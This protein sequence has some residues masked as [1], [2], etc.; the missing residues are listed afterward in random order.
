[1]QTNR[2]DNRLLVV[3]I[4]AAHSR[5]GVDPERL[6]LLA[7]YLREGV[8]SQGA[9]RAV[10]SALALRENFHPDDRDALR[11]FDIAAILGSIS[12]MKVGIVVFIGL[13]GTITLLIGGI[14]IANFHLA[15]LEERAAEI[16]VAK[17]LGARNRSLVA[18]TVLE[19]ALVSTTAGLLGLGVGYAITALASRMIPPG[20]FPTPEVS[21][22]VAMVTLGTLVGVTGLAAIV[23]ARRVSRIDISLAL[24]EGT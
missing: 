4:T 22:S 17:A 18:Q 12:L 9:L 14:G 8:D 7:V 20:L 3:P 10:T 13:A 24:R 19:S 23:P 1:M 16:G 5:R 15:T 6:S 2:P 11:S 21:P